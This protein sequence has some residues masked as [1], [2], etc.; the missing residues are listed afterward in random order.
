MVSGYIP[1]ALLLTGPQLR[2]GVLT[3]LAPILWGLG[4]FML[5]WC[6][7]DFL[8]KGRGTPAPIDPPK[9]LVV[10]GLYRHV[11]NPMYVGV[12]AVI[13]GHFVW[14]GYWFLL[15]YAAVIF[16]A[17]STFVLLYEEPHLRKTFGI[18]Y[19][20]YCEQVPRWI[21]RIKPRV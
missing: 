13:F 3:Y 12:L 5:I 1:L 20:E 6:F 14:F 15:I 10:S 18:M 4:L 17:F 9:H 7:W 21:P 8:S 16:A 11:R 19:E 2:M